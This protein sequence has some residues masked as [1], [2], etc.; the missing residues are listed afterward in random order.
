MKKT[1]VYLEPWVDLSLGRIA[2]AE[3]KS[4]AE[5]IRET[6]EAYVQRSRSLPRITEIGAGTGSPGDV[7]DNV[8][9]YLKGLGEE[10][11]EKD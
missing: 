11:L 6:L 8:D 10:G 3:G 7:A 2:Q 9:R 4:K 5:V 1:S